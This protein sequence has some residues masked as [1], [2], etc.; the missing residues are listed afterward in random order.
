MKKRAFDPSQG[1]G[2]TRNAKG[3]PQLLQGG[4]TYGYVEYHTEWKGD[5]IINPKTGQETDNRVPVTVFK[6]IPQQVDTEAEAL[7]DR[8]ELLQKALSLIPAIETLSKELRKLRD[9]KDSKVVDAKKAMERSRG[10][11]LALY[12]KVVTEYG[13]DVAKELTKEFKESDE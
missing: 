8:E 5:I 6:S 1:F 2:M 3:I 12:R 7:A 9:H 4:A 11:Y 10:Q 13:E